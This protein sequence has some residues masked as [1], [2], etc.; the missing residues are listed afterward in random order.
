LVAREGLKEVKKLILLGLYPLVILDE[1]NIAIYYKLFSVREPL[2]LIDAS[3]G[4]IEFVITVRYASPE[5][6]E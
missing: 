5:L 2:E 1:A 4:N 3:P 6:I